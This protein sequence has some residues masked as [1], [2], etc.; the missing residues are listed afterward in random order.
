MVWKWETETQH[1]AREAEKVMETKK[2]RTQREGVCVFVRW[3]AQQRA[4]CCTSMRLFSTQ[5]T[6]HSAAQNAGSSSIFLQVIILSV[7]TAW[8]DLHGAHYPTICMLFSTL[9]RCYGNLH[10]GNC[11]WLF[12]VSDSICKKEPGA[13]NVRF[14]Q[15]THL[16]NGFYGHMAIHPITIVIGH[17]A[18]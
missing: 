4:Y 12:Q 18:E 6:L 15:W 16:N 10:A 8:F 3:R 1:R 9:L 14:W 11:I 2:L 17:F 13:E 5:C 7:L